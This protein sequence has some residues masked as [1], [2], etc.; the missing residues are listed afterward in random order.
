M[1]GRYPATHSGTTSVCAGDRIE[2]E[3]TGSLVSCS[4]R[5]VADNR[6]KTSQ[7]RLVIYDGQ[8]RM[9]VTAR[10]GIERIRKAEER[11]SVRF[12][13]YQSEEATR[14]LGGMYRPW[15]PDVAYLVEPDGQI[16]Q[17]LDAFLPL[18]P[19][20]PGGPLLLALIRVPFIKPI[21]YLAYRLVARYRY[22]WFGEIE[23]SPAR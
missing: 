10:E 12:V 3:L 11:Q 8:C 15:R 23:D 1:T 5:V 9:C 13:P 4:D 6:S 19:G 16:K 20:L 22:R 7:G 21:V 14:S 2:E 18:L 17:G